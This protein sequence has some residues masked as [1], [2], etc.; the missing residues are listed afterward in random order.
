MR[1]IASPAEVSGNHR[2][3]QEANFGTYVELLNKEKVL[4]TI[5]L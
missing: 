3:T 1:S 4:L 5:I 2:Q